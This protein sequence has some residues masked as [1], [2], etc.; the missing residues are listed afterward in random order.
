[1]QIFLGVISRSLLGL[2]ILCLLHFLLPKGFHNLTVNLI[3]P[4]YNPQQDKKGDKEALCVE[5]FVQMIA[6]GKAKQDRPRHGQTQLGNQSQIIGP[7]VRFKKLKTLDIKTLFLVDSHYE[8]TTIVWRSSIVQASVSVNPD[9]PSR[10]HLPFDRIRAYVNG[11]SAFAFK[12]WRDKWRRA[13]GARK[14]L[15]NLL[16]CPGI[17]QNP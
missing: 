14:T 13:Q 10:C 12:L 5:P 11:A 1:M 9:P 15:E 3:T 4:A 7:F 16:W 8:N 17:A 6:D 2:V